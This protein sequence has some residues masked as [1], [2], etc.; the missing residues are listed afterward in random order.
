MSRGRQPSKRL[1]YKKVRQVGPGR[2]SDGR[3]LRL[4][5]LERGGR[6]WRYFTQRLTVRGKRR[7]L[8]IGSVADVSLGEAREIAE[9]NEKIARRGGDPRAEAAREK[10][11]TF[12][13]VYQV[14]TENRRQNWKTAKTAADWSR[15]FDRDILPA[16]GDMLVAD[17]TIRDVRDVVKPHWNGRGSKG[18]LARQNIEAVL[19]WAVANG[20]RP[21]NPAAAPQGHLAEGKEDRQASSQLAVP[22][23]ARSDG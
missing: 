10:G 11:P 13:E 17:I 23:G 12:A 20:H 15:M 6:L 3:G 8:G 4:L 5:V 22:R 16:I 2:Y 19:A 1:T 18:Y 7:D 14:V 9:K 21:D